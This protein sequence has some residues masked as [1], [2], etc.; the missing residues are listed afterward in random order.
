MALAFDRL[1]AGST[2]SSHVTPRD[3]ETDEAP[4]GQMADLLQ[5]WGFAVVLPRFVY[6]PLALFIAPP[7]QIIRIIKHQTP[8]LIQGSLVRRPHVR[9]HFPYDPYAAASHTKQ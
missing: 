3:K 1:S 5:G 8:R 4:C 2:A 7:V 6:Y 9:P